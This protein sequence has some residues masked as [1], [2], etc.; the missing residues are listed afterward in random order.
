MLLSLTAPAHGDTDVQLSLSMS[1]EWHRALY[2]RTERWFFS[3]GE[4]LYL[5]LVFPDIGFLDRGKVG[6]VVFP[7]YRYLKKGSPAGMGSI[8]Q[9]SVK[10]FIQSLLRGVSSIFW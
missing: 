8:P 7:I 3:L 5:C 10:D 9:D 2:E 4:H 1:G 6:V